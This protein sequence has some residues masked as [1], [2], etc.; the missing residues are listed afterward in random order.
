LQ[1]LPQRWALKNHTSPSGIET[2]DAVSDAF[3]TVL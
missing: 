1:S 2:I 3:G